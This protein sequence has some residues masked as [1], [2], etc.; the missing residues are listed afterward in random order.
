[1]NASTRLHLTR[2]VPFYIACLVVRSHAWTKMSA[3]VADFRIGPGVIKR[4]SNRQL[5]LQPLRVLLSCRPMGYYMET[6]HQQFSSKTRAMHR[7]KAEDWFCK[8]AQDRVQ[9]SQPRSRT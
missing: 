3:T 7:A 8:D 5:A 2:Q 6:L 9:V 1:M 4:R